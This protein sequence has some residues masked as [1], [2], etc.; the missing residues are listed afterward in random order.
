MRLAHSFLKP[1]KPIIPY[2]RDLVAF[3]DQRSA[4]AMCPANLSELEEK[5][6][7]EVDSYPNSLP[8]EGV[9]NPDKPCAIAKPK[10]G[11]WRRSQ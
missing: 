4:K 11:A 1:T 8:T 6:S 7:S 9:E 10:P 3:P 5:R 2:D